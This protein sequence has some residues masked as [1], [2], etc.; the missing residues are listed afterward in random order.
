[1][2]GAAGFSAAGLSCASAEMDS[3]A[4]SA[5]AVAGRNQHVIVIGP[6]RF[7]WMTT[8]ASSFGV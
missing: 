3:A 5:K 1:L 2:A 7:F 8:F 4:L 6:Y